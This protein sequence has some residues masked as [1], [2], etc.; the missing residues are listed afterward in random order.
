MLRKAKICSEVF[1]LS[2]EGNVTSCMVDELREAILPVIGKSQEI[3]IDL[4]QVAGIDFAGLSL[5]VDAKLTALAQGKELRFIRHSKP[6]VEIL[7]SSDLVGF[8]SVPQFGGEGAR[9]K[10]R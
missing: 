8:F 1:Q 10:R 3:E 4:S 5:M 9:Q 2:I 6:V 7:E